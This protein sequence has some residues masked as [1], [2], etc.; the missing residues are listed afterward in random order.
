MALINC[1]ECGRE[2]V[3]DSADMCP[4][5]GFGIKAHFEKIKME[6]ENKKRQLEIEEERESRLKN[7]MSEIEM[8]KK[9]ED[10]MEGNE[11]FLVGCGV[12]FII[13]GLL[14]ASD[15][16]IMLVMGVV[17]GTGFIIVGFKQ[18]NDEYQRKLKEYNLA[19]KDFE[20]YQRNK[21]HQQD[22]ASARRMADIANAPK[23]PMCNSINIEKISTT[24]RAVS[25]ATV[26]LA[27]GKI[28]KQYRCKKCKHMW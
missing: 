20:Q 5:C 23:C 27:S 11:K 28:G 22:M 13:I 1:P 10:K 8:P 16:V 25:V 21:I 9:P 18:K 26:G 4:D 19:V 17:C 12:F 24:S 7:R 2:K 15:T 6:E 3:S 14:A